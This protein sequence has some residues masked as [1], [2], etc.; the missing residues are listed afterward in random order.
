MFSSVKIEGE[1]GSEYAKLTDTNGDVF[2]WKSTRTRTWIKG[3]STLLT[4]TDDEY[5]ITGGAEGLSRSGRPFTVSILTPL[6]INMDCL[7]SG[8]YHPVSGVVAITPQ[9]ITTRELNYGAGSCDKLA[10]VTVGSYSRD[11]TLR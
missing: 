8:I 2:Q 5:S 9:N 3:S 7:L 4:L 6:L 1:N 11:I 10:T